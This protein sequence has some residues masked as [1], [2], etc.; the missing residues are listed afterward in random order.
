MGWVVDRETG[1]RS[2]CWDACGV[3]DL[4]RLFD[5]S[6]FA[7]VGSFTYWNSDGKTRCT[8]LFLP[9]LTTADEVNTTDS[10]H[11]TTGNLMAIQ[12]LWAK[13]MDR[14]SKLFRS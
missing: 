9:T 4:V 13:D 1:P 12:I 3:V 6:C 11:S 7:L 14:Q 10:V 8:G 5:D 2:H